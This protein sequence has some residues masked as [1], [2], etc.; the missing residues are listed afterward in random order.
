MTRLGLEVLGL[1]GAVF[2]GLYQQVSAS[3]ALA[4]MPAARAAGVRCFDVAPMYGL[5]RAELLLGNFLL[6]EI[7]EG[8]PAIVSTKVGRLI[9]DERYS[10]EPLRSGE[11]SP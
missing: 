2:G 7:G 4:T 8:A 5:G 3:D 9:A 10:R 1:G 6:E 11:K